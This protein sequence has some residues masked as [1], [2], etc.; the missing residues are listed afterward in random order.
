MP[1][2]EGSLAATAIVLSNS[3]TFLP[4]NALTPSK[5]LF[6]KMHLLSRIRRNPLPLVKSRLQLI[7]RFLNL[8]F[9]NIKRV[10]SRRHLS[11]LRN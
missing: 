11:V 3:S 1:Y 9:H 7:N 6:C 8:L 5:Q 2:Q 4:F 10:L